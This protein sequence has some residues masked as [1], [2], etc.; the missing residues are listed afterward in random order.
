MRGDGLDAQ[1]MALFPTSTPSSE[2][3]ASLAGK[4]QDMRPEVWGT[5]PMEEDLFVDPSLEGDDVIRVKREESEKSDSGIK[6]T[7]SIGSGS[8]TRRAPSSKSTASDRA[9]TSPSAST[10]VTPPPPTEE[11]VKSRTKT[12]QKPQKTSNDAPSSEARHKR[13][14]FLERNRVAATKCRQKKKQ[15]VAELEARKVALENQNQ[16]LLEQIKMLQDETGRLKYHLMA[17]AKCNDPNIDNWLNGEA[18]RFV[19]AQ[20][21]Q[22]MPQIPPAYHVGY[23]R[24]PVPDPTAQQSPISAGLAYPGSEIDGLSPLDRRVSIAYSHSEFYPQ[25]IPGNTD[26]AQ[27]HLCKLPLPSMAASPR[28]RH[29][30]LRSRTSKRRLTSTTCRTR[31]SARISPYSPPLRS[32]VPFV[33]LLS[34]K[35]NRFPHQHDWHDWNDIIRILISGGQGKGKGRSFC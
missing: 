29:R 25:A 30:P 17:H 33:S 16:Y 7:P 35:K 2:L 3:P 21:G 24:A 18:Q 31:C 22:Q 13:D 6:V 4:S 9:S 15:W 8:P 34:L 14:K 12:S 1:T 27:R 11:P 23:G 10:E 28:S 5:V 20:A 32:G 26:P 19:T